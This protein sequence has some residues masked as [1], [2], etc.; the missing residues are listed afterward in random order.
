MK[1]VII[2]ANRLEIVLGRFIFIGNT[3]KRS[4][5]SILQHIITTKCKKT[6]YRITRHRRPPGVKCDPREGKIEIFEKRLAPT[7]KKNHY[8]DLE[9][10]CSDKVT[11]IGVIVRWTKKNVI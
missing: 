7:A 1:M 6:K 3:S 8:A 2:N 4:N 11:K 9:D 5:S 10:T